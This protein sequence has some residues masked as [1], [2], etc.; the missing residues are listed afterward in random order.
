MTYTD[1]SFDFNKNLIRTIFPRAIESAIGVPQ[2]SCAESFAYCKEMSR[3]IPIYGV[4]FAA[5]FQ[6][7]EQRLD[8][9]MQ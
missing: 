3:T 1:A 4:L 7:W 8:V 6:F 2:K 9:A 5:K